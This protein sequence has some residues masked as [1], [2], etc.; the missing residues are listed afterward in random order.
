MELRELCFA[1]PF[2]VFPLCSFHL[3][4]D[5]LKTVANFIRREKLAPPDATLVAAISGGVDSM[6]MGEVLYRLKR[7]LRIRLVVA[8]FDHGLRPDS[9]S[10]LNFVRDWAEAH[11]LPFFG[12]SKDIAALSQGKN[13]EDVGR[14]ERYAFLRAVA[15]RCG[16]SSIATA[17]HRDDQAETV[18]LH[19]LRGSGVTGLAGIHPV[20]DDLVR[21]LLCVGRQE[22]M[23]FASAHN[24]EYREDPTNSSTHYLRNKIRLELLPYLCRYNPGISRELNDT[25]AICRDED[26]LLDELAEINLAQLWSVERSALDG[27]GF[28]LLS[29][30]LQRRVLRK[31]Y[32]LLA[33]DLPE[34][35]YRQV[36]AI[37]GLKD[38]QSCDLPRG[39]RAWR[40]HDICFGATMPELPRNDTVWPLLIDGQWH[41]LEGL[42]WSYHA[43][44]VDQSALAAARK[45]VE[46]ER[47]CLLL[48]ESL[49]PSAIW[50]TRRDGDYLERGS[51]LGCAKVKDIFIDNH[52]PGHA[53]AGWPLLISGTGETLWLPGLRT[54]A[55]DME[56]NNVLIKVRFSD[57]INFNPNHHHAK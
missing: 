5:L 10:D 43:Q 52:I 50:R 46:K 44:K 35:S 22:I 8:S 51:G 21:P 54:A 7:E 39:V 11:E 12:G 9:G 13:V 16:A 49:A 33:G 36:E 29:P 56:A 37:R 40:R 1:T 25:A 14:R 48:P 42:D 31:A 53:R 57:K 17:H 47:L 32:Q 6:V 3:T 34:L 23:E 24:I 18:L 26:A 41:E 2:I 45:S 20:R 38:E 28:S 19:L 15:A 27:P 55:F 4:M 30:A